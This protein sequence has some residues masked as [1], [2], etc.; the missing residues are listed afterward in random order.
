MADS[1][2]TNY[3]LTKPEVSVSKLWGAKLNTDMDLIDTQ[4]K[5]NADAT[6]LNTTHRGSDGKD[7][8]D[9]V[10][11]NTHRGLTNNP[12]SVTKTQVGLTNVTDNVQVIA[13]ATNTADSIPQWNGANSKTLKDGLVAGTAANNLVQLNGSAQLPAV[14]GSLLTGISMGVNGTVNPTNLLYGDFEC[15]SAGASAVPDGWGLSGATAAI[16]REASI[17]KLGTY[18]CKAIGN[19]SGASVQSIDFSLSKGISYWKGRTITLCVWV[20]ATVANQAH[21]GL[22]DGVDEVYSS[23]HTGNS[24]W[25]LLTKTHTVNAGATQLM[26]ELNVNP[27]NTAYFDGA[28]CVEGSS[29]FAFSPKPAEEGVWADYF[30]TSTKTGWAASPTGQIYTKKIG[31]TVFVAF[32]ITGTSD[33]TYAT[34]TV[35]YTSSNTVANVNVGYALNSGTGVTNGAL[36]L[37]PANDSIVTLYKGVDAGAWTNSGTKAIQGQ[38]FY[39]SA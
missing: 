22:Y 7:H 13:P 5:A 30:A 34:F 28:M 26:V 9:V 18:S 1:T 32:N 23:Y 4:M 24:T 20:Y 37:L 31:K 39:E 16:A 38:F 36:I 10:L 8:S 11:A 33:Q 6:A 2:T 29:A 12:H 15:W 35:P 25:Q 19:A 17:I 14:D 27:S 21:I 3:G